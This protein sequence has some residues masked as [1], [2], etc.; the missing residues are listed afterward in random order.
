MDIFA[1]IK[2]QV[3]MESAARYYGFEIARG[4]KI[5]C[6]FHNDSHPSLQLYKNGK[7]WW[8]YVCDMGGSVIDFVSKLYSLSPKE[9]AE[10][11]NA[12]FGLGI[13]I[14]HHMKHQRGLERRA[15]NH[16]R[17]SKRIEQDAF[18]VEYEKYQQEF[19]R[20]RQELDRTP[21]EQRSGAAMCRIAELE[22]WFEQHPYK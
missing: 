10:K 7:G 5:R 6:P 11:L 9:A 14:G 3:T 22:F 12:D 15:I 1:D 19:I 2:A 13:P 17:I 8:C 21:P 20:L 18:R 4:G 16:A